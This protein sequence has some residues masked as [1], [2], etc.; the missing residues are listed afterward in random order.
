MKS[1][2]RPI[3]FV[4]L[5]V[6]YVLLSVQLFGQGFTAAVSKN[7]VAVGEAFQIEFSI[8]NGGAD[9]FKPPVAFKDVDVYS[10]PNHSSSVQIINGSMSQSTSISYV[11]AAKSE[12]K[13]TIGPASITVGGSVKQSNSIVIEV[14]KGGG[15]NGGG[16]A[17]SGG[18]GRN[19]G[20][21][22]SGA[23]QGTTSEE[24][25]FARVSVD[26]SKVYLGEQITVVYKVYTRLNLRGFQDMKFPSCNGFWSQDVPQ[27]GQINL[28]T[29]NIEGVNYNVAEIKRTF[30]YPQ[31]SGTLEIDPL[32]VSCVVRQ[33][34]A[35]QPQSLFD[36][37]FGNG[38]FEDVVLKA[39]SKPIKIEVLPLPE[40]NKPADYSGAVGNYTFKT[41]LNKT[42]VK[43][44]E[45]ITLTITI[46]GSGNLKLID[47]LNVHIPEDIE[48]YDPKINDNVSVTN[49]GVS[50]S[51]TF[52]YLLIPRHAGDFKIDA[53]NFSFF[54]P[55]KRTYVS[56]PS[57]E[58]SIHV[59]KGKDDDVA[60]G[61]T[62]SSAIDKKDVMVVGKD[63]RY[64]KTGT[65]AFKKINDGFYGTEGFYGWL[66]APILLFG[67]LFV[68]R[69]KYLKDN[70]DGL[71]AKSK[72]ATKIA[73][74]RLTIAAKHSKDGNKEAFYEEVF[75]ALYGY[76]SDR[77]AIPYA[78]L[79]K[80]NVKE[81]LVSKKVSN[82]TC[83]KLDSILTSCEYARYAP[84]AVS[85]DL[86]AS[87]K[88]AV[89][90]ITQI[91]D[92][93]S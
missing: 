16:A 27:K 69:R 31:R 52:E 26:R 39:K 80:E 42:K 21:G 67:G 22:A 18:G 74:K 43:T 13:L 38:G 23:N 45:A 53:V 92:Q 10:G 75:K 85:S 51:K 46:S 24:N 71:L 4:L 7:R 56:I 84:S 59:D 6:T 93:L 91:E 37:F 2:R 47:A 81:M 60:T 57:P 90:I 34:S 25:L 49:A 41:T 73:K 44:N 14:V 86:G 62:F 55:E 64:I 63:I 77:L 5:S 17:A 88:E 70:A 58:F 12:G 36:Q 33:R 54:N 40:A 82:E 28:T 72:K 30:L 15:G 89:L 11:I 50:G 68:A 65:P 87:Y 3:Y 66:L 83:D 32:E 19:Q 35:R 8:S 76:L 29:E 48:K 9:N 79:T 20:G 78:N 61:T 1:I